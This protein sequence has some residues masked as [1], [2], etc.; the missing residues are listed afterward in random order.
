LCSS[1]SGAG[2]MYRWGAALQFQCGCKMVLRLL[3]M[4]SRM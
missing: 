1:G 4:T 3:S 2:Q